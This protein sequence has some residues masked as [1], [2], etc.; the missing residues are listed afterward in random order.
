MAVLA[1]FVAVVLATAMF[2]S[3]QNTLLCRGCTVS[4]GSCPPGWVP[5]GRRCYAVNPSRLLQVEAKAHCVDHG[6]GMA[7][8]RSQHEGAFLRALLAKEVPD[9]KAAWIDCLS[10]PEGRV[11]SLECEGVVR[12]RN[13]YRNW[14]AGEPNEEGE[15]CVIMFRSDGKWLD[16][17]C[18][19]KRV[20]ICQRPSNFL[21]I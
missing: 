7:A 9:V 4:T 10:R 2:K 1:R 12:G 21:H 6:A 8:P 5:W 13:G 20:S 3:P 11:Y 17:L 14:A 19:T 15:S 18:T 16:A